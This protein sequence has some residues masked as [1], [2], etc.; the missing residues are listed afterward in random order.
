MA[1][2]SGP[3]T[4]DSGADPCSTTP[5]SVSGLTD[6]TQISAGDQP[7]CA[8]RSS[9]SIDCWG[10]NDCGELGDGTEAGPDTCG[11]GSPCSTVPVAVTGVT[12]ATQ[13]GAG[14]TADAWA[15]VSGGGID[16]WGYNGSGEFRDGTL[17]NSDQPTA[18]PGFG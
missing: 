4:C 1:T 13:I 11:A 6:A 18:V 7:M 10:H 12:D 15:V 9:G 14:G 2:D 3:S 8:L 16:C 5:V 17:T